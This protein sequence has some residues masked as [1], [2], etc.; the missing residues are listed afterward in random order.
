[1]FP[2]ATFSIVAFDPNRQEWGVAVQ[3]KF[4]AVGAVVSWARA[5]A[6]AIATQAYGNLTYGPAGLQLLAEGMD[7]GDVVRTLTSDD[8]KRSLRQ[9]GIVDAR[10]KVAAFTGDDCD[11]WAG[12]ITG[13]GYICLGNIL[14]PGT[15]EA[16]AHRFEARR[17]DGT[18]ELA[19]WLVDA[20]QAGQEAGG[21]R[22]G[23]QSAAVLVVRENGGFGGNNDRYLDLRV[24]DHAQPI[25]ELHRLLQL[26]HN[27]FKP[28]NGGLREKSE[29]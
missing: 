21:D 15:V 16:M 1:M 9:L 20:L 22:R 14:V 23:R 7:A 29:A 27:L 2:I 11:D 13:D 5:G 26:H 6:G 4:L 25:R 17:K 24:D 8:E 28:T 19:D 10:G 3:S 18:G 12:H